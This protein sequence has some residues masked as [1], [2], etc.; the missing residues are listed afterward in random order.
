MSALR[1]AAGIGA[2]VALAALLAGST[3]RGAAAGEEGAPAGASPGDGG[4]RDDGPG[5]REEAA[6]REDSGPPRETPAVGRGVLARAAAARAA[7]APARGPHGRRAPANGEAGDA[8]V[9][10]VEVDWG[11]PPARP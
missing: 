7:G 11:A 6:T 2:G 5:V 8:I 3:G 10:S 9:E 1:F 4:R